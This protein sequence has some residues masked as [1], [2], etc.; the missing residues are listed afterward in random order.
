MRPSLCLHKLLWLFPLLVLGCGDVV[1]E[2]S[3]AQLVQHQAGY[4]GR[5]VITRGV[6]RHFE[7]PLHYWIEDADLNRVALEPGD[8][9]AD[10]VGDRVQVQ[11]T[12]VVSRDG[13]RM[14]RAERVD[15]IDD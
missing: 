9:V 4:N 8:R 7:D 2:R 10:H 3:L 13:G 15:P 11:G 14:I 12:F 6:V 1:L 5:E